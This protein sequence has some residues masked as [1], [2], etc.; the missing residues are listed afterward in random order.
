MNSVKQVDWYFDY[1]SPFAYL[2]S[3]R[4]E[5]IAEQV[6]IRYRPVLFAGLL[7]HWEHKGPAEI[8]G[9]RVLTFRYANWL[10]G[11]LGIPY[12]LPDH[13]PFNPLRALRLTLALGCSDHVIR[14]IFRA[15]W[16]DGLMPDTQEGWHAIL[17][18]LQVENSEALISQA[19]V[20]ST[21]RDNGEQAVA[22]EVFG[23][24][25]FVAGGQLF[26]GLDA[27]DMLLDYLS[28]PHLFEDPEMV[29]ILDVKPS[30]TRRG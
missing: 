24:P 10:A 3:H 5:E 9:K 8:P 7:R 15:I 21:L 23:V 26:W 14:T 20:K 22:Q 28:N 16:V 12:R 18:R 2:Q 17:E 19:S 29:R 6:K 30:T 1:I 13:H 11:K 27:T 25:T 4:L